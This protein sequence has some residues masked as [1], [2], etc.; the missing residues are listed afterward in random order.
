MLPLSSQL[1]TAWS[2]AL[3]AVWSPPEFNDDQSDN[4]LTRAMNNRRGRGLRAAILLAA[5]ERHDRAAV[6][7]IF[8]DTL[9][10]VL[11]VVGMPGMEFRAI[12]AGHRRLLEQIAGSWLDQQADAL[13]RGDAGPDTVVLTLRYAQP[14]PSPCRGSTPHSLGEASLRLG[15]SERSA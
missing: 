4:P 8:V 10:D 6:R 11:T 7:A 12:L 15:E 2:W 1:D 3:E 9:D 5:W 14:T 13:F